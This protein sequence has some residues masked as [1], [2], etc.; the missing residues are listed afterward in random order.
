MIQQTYSFKQGN[1]ADTVNITS[2]VIATGTSDANG[3]A[4]F[5]DLKGAAFYLIKAEPP[6]G[7]NLGPATTF[8]NQAFVDKV[9]LTMILHGL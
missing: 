8:T 5:P 7:S 2:T 3:D 4:V 1:G 6:K 9:K